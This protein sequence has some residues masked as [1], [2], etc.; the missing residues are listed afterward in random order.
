MRSGHQLRN[1]KKINTTSY[2][3]KKRY[4]VVRRLEDEEYLFHLRTA[5]T[6]ER[7]RQKENMKLVKNE[8]NFHR[9]FI[10]RCI[11]IPHHHHHRCDGFAAVSFVLCVVDE[12]H[13]LNE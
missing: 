13:V 6:N 8:N 10:M 11:R 5:T 12:L 2:S 3:L 4:P 1:E 9:I 7:T